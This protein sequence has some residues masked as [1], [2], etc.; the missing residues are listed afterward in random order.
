MR[1][2][3][4]ASAPPWRSRRG[5]SATGR[6]RTCSVASSTESTRR[7]TPSI[8]GAPRTLSVA[9]ALGHFDRSDPWVAENWDGHRR[10]AARTDEAR[11]RLGA[12]PGGTRR[13]GALATQPALERRLM[14]WEEALRPTDAP[15]TSE[16]FGWFEPDDPAGLA[17]LPVEIHATPPPISRSTAPRAPGGHEALTRPHERPGRSASARGSLPTGGPCSSSSRRLRRR[18]STTRSSS[19]SSRAASLRPR[20]CCPEKGPLA[21]LA[22]HLWHSERWFLHERP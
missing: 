2:P 22:R 10:V 6:R 17:L 1:P 18:R 16:S 9:D 5:A 14:D 7:R 12:G 19:R 3:T 20:R 15:A 4:W 11:L 13:R 21:H 8:L